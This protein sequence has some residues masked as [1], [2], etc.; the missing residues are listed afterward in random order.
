MESSGSSSSSYY[1]ISLTS[2]SESSSSDSFPSDPLIIGSE[3]FS[4]GG[5]V[6][7]GAGFKTLATRSTVS[8]WEVREAPAFELS[9]CPSKIR[10][11]GEEHDL[12]WDSSTCP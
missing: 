3:F 11:L 10:S 9:S 1:D 7:A 5:G 8:L 6:E 4:V 12:R 2:P